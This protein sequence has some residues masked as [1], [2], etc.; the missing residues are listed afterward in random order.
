MYWAVKRGQ[1]GQMQN[2]A[3]VI[4]RLTHVLFAEANPAP[5]KCAL[6]LLNVMWPRVRFPLVELNDAAKA[7]ISSVLAEVHERCRED[8]VG[9]LTAA[10]PNVHRSSIRVMAN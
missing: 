6:S 4:H 7:D 5:L 3:A 9:D 2:L 8:V 1:V 10:D